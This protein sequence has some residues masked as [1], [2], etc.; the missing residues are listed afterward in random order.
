MIRI[1]AGKYRSRMI[2][3]PPSN[4]TMPTKESTRE[5]IFSALGEKITN[6]E[7][8]DLFSGSGAL[9]IESLSRGAKHAVM[10]DSSLESIRII[11]ENLALLKETSAEV[12]NMDYEDALSKFSQE[13]RTFD[14]IFLDPP[15]KDNIY[16]HIINVLI[17]DKMLSKFAIIVVES[18]HNIIFDET[19]FTKIKSYKYG[20]SIVYI[21][22][23][24]V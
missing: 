9:A 13:K 22:R 19:L 18:N 11:N 23:S 16:K 20:Y 2:K 6:A 7:V 12:L 14:I 17:R 3:T 1:V 15:Y 21:L 24:G 8:L 4:L 5:G 10:V